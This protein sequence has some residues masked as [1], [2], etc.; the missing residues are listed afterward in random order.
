M[1]PLPQSSL[2]ADDLNEDNTHNLPPSEGSINSDLRRLDRVA[3][4]I[5]DE[6]MKTGHDYTNHVP[7]LAI[8]E[9]IGLDERNRHFMNI[10]DMRAIKSRLEKNKGCGEVKCFGLSLPSLPGVKECK[11]G[12]SKDR[13]LHTIDEELWLS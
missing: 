12:F 1:T 10:V 2:S 3:A 13:G 7:G 4:Q 9:P 11:E 5:R 8:E 6:M